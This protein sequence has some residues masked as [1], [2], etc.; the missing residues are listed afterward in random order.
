[1]Q[2]RN[3]TATNTL[4]NHSTTATT[5]HRPFLEIKDVTKG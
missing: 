5:S 4:G 1:M 3:L 2:N